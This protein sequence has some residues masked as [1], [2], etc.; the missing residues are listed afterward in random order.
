MLS[1]RKDKLI[2][3]VSTVY[4][5]EIP[6]NIYELGLIYDITEDDDGNVKILMSLT[7]PNC[8]EAERLP[9]MVKNAVMSVEGVNTVNVEITF[10]PPWTPEKM[11]S[12]A[13]IALDMLY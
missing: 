10:E 11:S 8:P 5:P 1:E 4:D 9:E 6:V 3:A 7:A 12:G 2:E 13:K